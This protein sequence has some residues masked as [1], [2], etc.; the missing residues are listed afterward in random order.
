MVFENTESGNTSINIKML[1]PG[2]Y[3]VKISDNEEV[4]QEKF[5]KL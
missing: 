1:Q 3:V 2:N 4:W 5:I